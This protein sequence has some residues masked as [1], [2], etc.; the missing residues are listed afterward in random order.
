MTRTAALPSATPSPQ[1]QVMAIAMGVT[2][3]RCLVAAAELGIA[4]ALA[5]G[6]LHVD[7]ICAEIK[8]DGRNLFRL[9]RALETIG[10]FQQVSPRVF[11]NT[12][13]SDCLRSDAAGSQRAFLQLLAPGLGI[14]DGYTEMLST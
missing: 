8:A 7:S 9:M 13:L 3:G 11:A 12:P 14:W 5:K 10:V 2:Q 1:E 4:D 6:P